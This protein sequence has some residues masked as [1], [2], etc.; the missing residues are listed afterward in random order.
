MA[1]QEFQA[2]CNHHAVMGEARFMHAQVAS[3][4]GA[5]A[6]H[7]G[8]GFLSE[9]TTFAMKCQ[10]AGIAFVGPPAAAIAAMGACCRHVPHAVIK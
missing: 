1:E 10:K 3:R 5:S 9:N 2:Y 6:I 8:Y 7:P 4:T